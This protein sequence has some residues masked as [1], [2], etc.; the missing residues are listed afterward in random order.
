MVSKKSWL[1]VSVSRKKVQY[2]SGFQNGISDPGGF[3]GRVLSKTMTAIVLV[4]W[5]QIYV[6]MFKTY[7]S[8]IKKTK[9]YRT[10]YM[11]V[12]IRL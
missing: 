2:S 10:V 4:K 11:D 9:R 8:P 1:R 7:Y 12:E 5:K 3:M 6:Y